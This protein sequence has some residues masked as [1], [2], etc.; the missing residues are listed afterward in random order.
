MLERIRG[1]SVREWVVPPHCDNLQSTYRLTTFP[2][3][4]KSNMDSAVFI[5]SQYLCLLRALLNK[6]DYV[7]ALSCFSLLGACYMGTAVLE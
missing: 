3:L 2:E 5:S 1:P 4:K 6:D 7:D